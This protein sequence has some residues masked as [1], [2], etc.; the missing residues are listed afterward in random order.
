MTDRDNLSDDYVPLKNRGGSSG[1]RDEEPILKPRTFLSKFFWVS[2]GLVGSMVLVLIAVFF[3]LEYVLPSD[4]PP[5]L[6]NVSNVNAV[7]GDGQ[8]ANYIVRRAPAVKNDTVWT[9]RLEGEGLCFNEVSCHHR[10]NH[11][12]MGKFMSPIPADADQRGLNHWLDPDGLF[13]F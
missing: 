12:M 4:L 2:V 1:I 5:T 10:A 3:Y 6:V 13:L 9:I 11:S 7:C 8:L